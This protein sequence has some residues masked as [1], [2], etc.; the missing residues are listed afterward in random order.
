MNLLSLGVLGPPP[1]CLSH[2][3][4]LLETGLCSMKSKMGLEAGVPQT[5]LHGRAIRMVV[6]ARAPQ[7]WPFT[8]LAQLVKEGPTAQTLLQQRDLR[9]P[10]T[11]EQGPQCP[12][13]GKKEADALVPS[14]SPCHTQGQPPPGLP[15]G[16]R[17]F[18]GA[19]WDSVSPPGNRKQC[20]ISSWSFTAA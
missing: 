3:I 20:D 2:Q 12:F 18:H 10:G 15:R 4:K 1:H 14:S 17:A 19:A 13:L 8:S 9:C 5:G 11:Q 7:A 6:P 16:L